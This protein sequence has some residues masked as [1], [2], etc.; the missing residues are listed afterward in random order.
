MRQRTAA[1]IGGA[2]AALALA[3]IGASVVR[4]GMPV[5]CPAI[6]YVETIDVRLSGDTAAVQDLRL[7]SSA[8]C[9]RPS[10]EEPTPDP[11]DGLIPDSAFTSER[12]RAAEWQF[13]VIGPHP[14]RVEVTAVDAAD[15]ALVSKNYPLTWSRVDPSSQCNTSMETSPIRLVV[16]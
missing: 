1:V 12:L 16:P 8:G 6:G 5:T 7:C 9:S 3:A 10:G 4:V 14:T 2:A 15:T 11:T 13:S